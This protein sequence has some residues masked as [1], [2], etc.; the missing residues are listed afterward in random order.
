M[1]DAANTYKVYIAW[2]DEMYAR[3]SLYAEYRKDSTLA[4]DDLLDNKLSLAYEKLSKEIPEY[5]NLDNG[6]KQWCQHVQN[7]FA[8]IL[9]SHIM[10]LATSLKIRNLTNMKQGT[11]K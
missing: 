9:T 4:E 8:N 3:V 10:Y 11:K 1:T 6:Y 2:L 7:E 5:M